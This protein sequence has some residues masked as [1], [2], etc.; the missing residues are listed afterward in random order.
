MFM[1][2]QKYNCYENT[3]KRLNTEMRQIG[4]VMLQ[5]FILMH[6]LAW[7]LQEQKKIA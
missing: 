1:E 3:L 7:I 5:R 4:K 2:N 6:Y